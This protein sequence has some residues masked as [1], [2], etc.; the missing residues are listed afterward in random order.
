MGETLTSTA[1]IARSLC[2]DIKPASDVELH[3]LYDPFRPET[4]EVHD[5]EFRDC[6][7]LDE[8]LGDLPEAEY[9]LF[10]NGVEV[11]L[12][13]ASSVAVSRGDKIGL[14]VLPLG[15]G[16]GLK[17]I[18]RT[19]TTIAFTVGGFLIGGPL[20]ASIGAAVGSLIGSLLFVPKPP[21]S[22]DEGERTYGIDGAKNSATE[23]IPYPVV[24]GEFRQAGN[25][26]DTYTENVGETQYLYLRSIMNDGQAESITDIELNE[27]PVANF[28]D[29]QTRIG[30][31]TLT[32]PVNE[33]F[34]SSV[35]QVNKSVKLDTA[36]TTHVTT[37]EVDQIRFDVTFPAGL[38]SISEK[39]GTYKK[40]SV[41]FQ[42]EYRQVN[43]S[44]D[45]LAGVAGTWQETPHFEPENDFLFDGFGSGVL[46]E[47]I[48]LSSAQSSRVN[49]QAAAAPLS[50]AA[51][52]G[53]KVQF[54][55]VLGGD[56]TDIESIA[57]NA[58]SQG[59]VPD[60]S[61]NGT[62]A[63]PTNITPYATQ[64]IEFNLPAG[65]YDIRGINGAV[66]NRVTS[67]PNSGQ[68]S[69]TVTDSRT[70]AIRRSFTTQR[71][72]RG[73]YEFRVRRTTATS[74]NQY[75]ID[76]VILTDV[77]EI[78]ADPVA[79][80]GTANLSLRIKLNDQLNNIPQVTALVKGCVLQEFDR[81]GN[82]TVRRWSAN[83]AWI[84]LDILCSQERGG[85]L[86][87]SRIDWPRWVEYAEWCDANGIVFNG[88][89]ATE[90]N[91][92]DAVREVLRIG[93]ATPVPFGTKVSLAV[94]RPRDP[95]TMFTQASMI[96]GSFNIGY[97]S[98]QDRSN[99]F[100]ITYYDK[101]DRNKAKTIR[102]VD[103][104]AVTFNEIPRS[105]Q[106]SLVGVDNIVQAR[107]ELWRMI[108]QNR[109]LIRTATFDAF[110]EAI[111]LSIGEVALIQHNQMEWANNGR[112]A[113]GSSAD[114]VNLDQEV[115]KL[116]GVDYSL[117]AHLSAVNRVPDR[118]VTAVSGNKVMFDRAGANLTS[119]Q[120]KAT[121]LKSSTGQDY[122]I[123]KLESGASFHTATL[124]AAPDGISTGSIV[125][126]FQTDVIEERV[127]SSVT[128]NP[129]GTSSV[130]L[131]SALPAAPEQ[132]SNFVYGRVERV[133]KPYVLTGVSGNGLE[134]RRLSFMEYNEA[135]YGPG[136]VE[137]PTPV[138]QLNDRIVNHVQGLLFDY[139][140]I[141][142]ANRKTTNLRLFWNA[143]AIRN[144]GGADVFMRLNGSGWVAVGSAVN[145]SEFNVQLTPG[146]FAEF[147]VN[148]Y[149]TRGD[150]ASI[151]TAPV[152]AGTLMVER[153]SLDAPTSFS[154]VM[155]GF[156][157][158]GTVA[159]AFTAPL[160]TS[161][162]EGYEIEVRHVDDVN[163]FSLGR[164][165]GTSHVQ[166]GVPPGGYLA[167]VRSV[168][169]D[170]TSV[171][172]N[173]S[174]AISVLPGSLLSNYNGGND[175]N[176]DPITSPTLPATGSVEHIVNTDGSATVSL[177][178]LWSGDEGDIDGFRI[179]MTGS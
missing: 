62:V 119:D 116:P 76:E 136:E 59:F 120:L 175:R 154:A 2:A 150:R 102:Y 95:V 72:A 86:S 67:Y 176:G 94:D 173:T 19:L 82:P 15:G 178:W 75:E 39:K 26:A 34:R 118:T 117:L 93:R 127:V 155:S 145:V 7:T 68:S 98:M 137:L 140:R 134:K 114:L 164:F 170:S 55:P 21:K 122:E 92:G 61:G 64:D 125:S 36:W 40:K 6:L 156:E 11:E 143:N 32:Q 112:T 87:L 135:V 63:G 179:T 130:A 65:D 43:Q 103:P 97:L 167:R 115:E 144:Y 45:P 33:W 107:D 10:H 171:W 100:E 51:A 148:A 1:A 161:G 159:Y 42:T 41:T 79:M 129:D 60:A 53:P 160:D 13:E 151:S 99:E 131:S 96:K 14:I 147:K 30:L 50:T 91:V 166:T 74:T 77:V 124:T 29:V 132:Y 108:Y 4:A 104:K 5:L 48:R 58:I 83:P 168:S 149:S 139:D 17:S 172:V 31:G 81:E 25:F 3:L 174:F 71:L 141:V 69:F 89:F 153:A 24:Y 162:I 38:V 85:L 16:G 37:Q 158:D 12:E 73:Y 101:T 121:R 128:Q 163:W 49:V 126:L 123:A 80:R 146:D 28:R 66:V 105:A 70:R 9:M 88:V 109:L 22:Q 152:V 57:I 47:A 84:A 27:Q 138:F 113:A 18:L 8:Y 52:A 165:A 157:V 56:W 142:D 133:R 23:G 78:E 106:V 110:L 177:E 169:T 54:K 44:G 46:N 35:R 111:N 90:S 20:G